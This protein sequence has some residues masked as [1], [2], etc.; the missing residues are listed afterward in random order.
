MRHG[1]AAAQ[2]L[3]AVNASIEMIGRSVAPQPYPD[4]EAGWR[5]RY[6]ALIDAYEQGDYSAADVRSLHLFKAEDTDGKE[7]DIARRLFS[8]FRFICDVDARALIGPKGLTLE[9]PDWVDDQMLADAERVWARSKLRQKLG[10]WARLTAVTG[11]YY[12]EAV[13]TNAAA[14]FGTKLVGYPADWVTPVYD[15]LGD[16]LVRVD[17]DFIYLDEPAPNQTALSE[18][19]QHSYRRVIDRDFVEVFIDGKSQGKKPHY[20]G[21]VPAVHLYWTPWLAPEHSLSAAHGADASTHR[22]DSLVAQVGAISNRF[23]DPKLVVKGAK[24]EA[25]ADLSFGRVISGL[26]T[27]GDAYYLEAGA[28]ALGPILEVA[29]EVMNHIRETAPEFLFADAKAAESGTARSFKAAALEMKI[30]EVREHWLS[31]LAEITGVAVAMGRN[32]TYKPDAHALHIDAASFI[33]PNLDAEVQMLV[34]ARPMLLKRD[35]VRRLQALGLA[36]TDLTVEDY[37]QALDDE[38][39]MAGGPVNDGNQ[40]PG[41]S[42]PVGGSADSTPA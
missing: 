9:A 41:G 22:L 8:Y 31:A 34:S 33:Q 28:A 18:A 27:D 40:G 6:N 21:R 1:T 29:R 23:A 19:I 16:E 35:V 13:R 42:D 24:V 32:E 4:T 17:I 7:V 25:G 11:D 39:A 20:A 5:Q 37:V 10:R 12:V 15:E 3:S 30:G 38:Q 14:P 2:T 26:P 36:S